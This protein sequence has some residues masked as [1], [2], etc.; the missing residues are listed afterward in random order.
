MFEPQSLRAVPYTPQATGLVPA[1]LPL[2]PLLAPTPSFVVLKT[3]VTVAVPRGLGRLPAKAGTRRRGVQAWSPPRGEAPRGDAPVLT[4][5][6]SRVPKPGPVSIGHTG[7]AGRS[8]E[9]PADYAPP[10]ALWDGSWEGQ[11]LSSRAWEVALG[12]RAS[13]ELFLPRR[14]GGTLGAAKR[15]AARC[16]Q[17]RPGRGGRASCIFTPARP[18]LRSAPGR[19]LA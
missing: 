19:A 3:P 14:G 7:W 4:P 15:P 2:P 5:P 9:G 17:V 10:S 18:R 13:R 8:Q 6:R 11:R 1:P 16:A 12:R